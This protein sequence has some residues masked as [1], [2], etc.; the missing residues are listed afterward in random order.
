MRVFLITVLALV[1]FA[2]NSVLN[3]AALAGAGMEPGL[4]TAIRLMSGALML[5]AI[6]RLSGGRGVGG[7]WA[8]AGALVVYAVAFSYAYQWL[9]AGVGAL[10]LFGSVQIT[11]FAGG[12]L[13]GQRP[14]GWRWLGSG[15]GLAGLGVLFLPGAA[16]PGVAGVAL[17]VLAG[18]A[19]GV[20][21]LRGAT[22]G[23]ALRAT[24]GNFLRS[25]P[26]GV[27]LLLPVGFGAETQLSAA[28]VA[29][30]V[31]SGALASGL[32][33]A[34]WY[35]ALPHLDPAIAAIAQLTV[36]LI[37][38]VGGMIWLA[39]VPTPAF[40]LAAGLILGGV[41]LAVFGPRLSAGRN[42]R[43]G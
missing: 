33:Y 13:G 35:S 5:M 42:T 8:S 17:M 19:W 29:L 9:D 41:V 23:A 10:I 28:G 1:A 43:G 12:L 31:A 2:A 30:A 32:G 34:V 7:S 21:S 22:S 38:L 27:A 15:L 18:I 24:A 40:A 37:A 14:G 25:V 3:R 6:F 4:F 16:A 39:E 20:Y 26:V 11:M 36:P